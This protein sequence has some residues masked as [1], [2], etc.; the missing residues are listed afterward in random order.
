MANRPS[1]VIREKLYAACHG[2]GNML[3]RNHANHA[4]H[5]LR[6]HVRDDG[7][8]EG[9]RGMGICD[10]FDDVERHLIF[11]DDD[12]I[13]ASQVAKFRFIEQKVHDVANCAI[14]YRRSMTLL[15]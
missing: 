15:I 13:L 8:N 10:H 9:H 7:N 11:A 1:D 2:I 12:K 6:S 5:F 14:G 4:R 3:P